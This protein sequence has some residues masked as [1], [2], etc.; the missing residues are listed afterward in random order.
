VQGEP[1]ALAHSGPTAED[2]RERK[3]ALDWEP[4]PA[5]VAELSQQLGVPPAVILEAAGEFKSYWVIGGGAGKARR[6]WNGKFR[7]HCRR[8]HG[9]GRLRS[10][11]TNGKPIDPEHEKKLAS[12]RKH[13][14][15]LE[16]QTGRAFA[17]DEV[18]CDVMAVGR[19]LST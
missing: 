6:N 11:D 1:L 3:L 9:E 8:A 19:A 10:I 12:A 18:T 2:D 4:H 17:V 5:T 13:A 14:K 16:E 15:R 7:E